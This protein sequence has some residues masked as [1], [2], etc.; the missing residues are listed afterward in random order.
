MRRTHTI[1]IRVTLTEKHRME[2]K[3][4][5]SGVSLSDLVRRHL[6]ECR[7]RQT[8]EEK[9]RVRQLAR[10]GNNINQLARWANAYKGRAESV[11]VLLHLEQLWEVCRG[12]PPC[13]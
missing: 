4:S 13:T 1:K 11:D 5:A 2:A 9:E 6:Q 12:G 8:P 3:A 7:L 10:V